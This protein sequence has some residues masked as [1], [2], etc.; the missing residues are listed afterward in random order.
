[1]ARGPA[2]HRLEHLK[3]G[4]RCCVRTGQ[5][6]EDTSSDRRLSGLP[7]SGVMKD[8]GRRGGFIFLAALAAACAL[9][10]A[11]GAVT[12][13]TGFQQRHELTGLTRPTKIA[14]A[15]DGRRFVIEKDGVLRAAPATG[16]A[17]QVVLDIRADVN[18]AGDRGLLGLAVDSDFANQPY[19]YLLYTYDLKKATNPNS[20][21]PMVSRLLRVKVSATNQ[22]LERKTLLGSYLSGACPAPANTWTASLPTARHIQSGPSSPLPTGRLFVGNGDA[23]GFD[24]LDPLSLRTYNEASM[25][26]KIM[27]VDR[28]GRGLAG[29]S[30]LPR[31][32]RPDARLHEALGEGLPQPVPIHPTSQRLPDGRRRGLDPT[33]R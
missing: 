9:A 2:V 1:M 19:L 15:P 29:P 8:L 33:R 24:Q 10:P 28:E 4:S 25:A 17:S 11:A 21:D 5:A 32:G 13:P 20:E 3:D 27:H 18:D 31:P 30:L 23:A 6:A 26:G 16:T 22:V 7:L 12:L 14:W